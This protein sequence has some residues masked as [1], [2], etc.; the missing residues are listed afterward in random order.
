SPMVAD[1]WR[2]HAQMGAYAPI[3]YEPDVVGVPN[4]EVKKRR[5]SALRVNMIGRRTRILK[6]LG[7]ALG[8]RLLPVECFGMD[9][10]HQLDKSRIDLYVGHSDDLSFPGTRLWQVL[11]PSAARVT[12]RRD[13][14]PA[15]SG[16]HFIELEPED[17]ER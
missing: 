9:R 11:G 12:E 15:V 3:G 14:W 10:K 5:D 1:F 16:R 7:R 13:A 2:P 4:W 8:E 17:P 6:D